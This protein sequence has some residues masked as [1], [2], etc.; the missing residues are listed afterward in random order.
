MT[1]D[2]LMH[3]DD[4]RTTRQQA[5]FDATK[6]LTISVT[7]SSGDIKFTAGDR[8]DVEIIAERL[9]SART[10][11]EARI[12][13]NVE[14]NKISVHPNWQIGNTIGEI[15][16]KVKHQLKEGFN[17]DEWDLKNMKL[18]VNARF[19]IRVEVPRDLPD[20]SMVSVKAASG[21]I[22]MADISAR[23]TAATANGDITLDRLTG[24]ISSHSASGDIT[25]N[26]INGS[27]ESNTGNG[28]IKVDGGEAW[29]AL[30]AVNGDIRATGLTMKNARVTT[31]SGDVDAN[32]TM[33]NKASY[34]FDTVSGDITLNTTLPTTGASLGFKAVNG[35][36]KVSGDWI[37]ASGKRAWQL[38]AGNEGPEIRAKAVSG[39][40]KAAGSA[41]PSVGLTHATPP[42][43]TAT[44]HESTG[45][46]ETGTDFDWEKAKGWVSSVTQKISQVVNEMDE[47]GDRHRA[48]DAPS[49]STGVA[50]TEP[51]PSR[52]AMPPVT[53]PPPVPPV[54]HMHHHEHQTDDA[55]T[56]PVDVPSFSA[57]THPIPT[58][59]PV[60]DETETT[61]Q[62]R[63]RLLEAVQRGEMT[64]DEA[65]AQLDGD[66]SDQ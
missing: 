49:G 9:D 7:N 31:V 4:A 11:D 35:S 44:D 40:L 33:N 46:E 3:L 52:P 29:T 10:N 42:Q 39:D 5:A 34:T 51:M 6:P 47:A 30:R 22:S 25:L 65:L 32:V 27:I 41:D 60:A 63:L 2:S 45:M 24:K 38:A 58:P 37:P 15:A 16:K 50:D 18:G 17:S 26:T 23:V 8:L 61:G 48:K 1:N 56:E 36:A 14:G 57:E 59:P 53:P 21:D 62:R 55:S 28:N 66:S 13:I 12:E 64:V 19:D 20:G 54:S 43:E